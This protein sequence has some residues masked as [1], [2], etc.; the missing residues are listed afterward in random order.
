MPRAAEYL[1]K[2]EMSGQHTP[3]R[4]GPWCFDH[5]I[6]PEV[7]LFRGALGGGAPA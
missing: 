3:T 4:L 5:V 1:D 6:R 7:G 2:R